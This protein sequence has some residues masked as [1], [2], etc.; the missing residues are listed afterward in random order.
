[1]KKRI[2]GLLLL[3]PLLSLSSC[4]DL[5]DDND[6]DDVKG[7][8]EAEQ[9]ILKKEW[10][11]K[12]FRDDDDGDD[13]TPRVKDYRFI[14]KDN[15]EM[16]I[17]R[18]KKSAVVGEWKFQ[19]NNRW[20]KIDLDDADDILD[21]LEDDWYIFNLSENRFECRGDDDDDD[22]DEFLILVR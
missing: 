6:D 22:D 2:F 16:V 19:R 12:L 15:G 21:D 13:D 1:M 20:L 10:R 8:P 4:D 3:L 17:E 18:P 7:T 5:F 14:F 11:V 9:V